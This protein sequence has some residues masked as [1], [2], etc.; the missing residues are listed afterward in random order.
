MAASSSYA[1]AVTKATDTAR[2]A[3]PPPAR[4]KPK[5]PKQMKNEVSVGF[6]LNTNGWSTYADLGKVKAL[7]AKNSDMFHNVRF[8]QVEFT[9][10]KS[11]REQKQDGANTSG[12]GPTTYIYGK[13]N[14][15]YALKIGYGLRKMIAGKPD[16]GTVS[17]HWLSAIG[18]SAG[19]L[20]PYYIN[21]KDF[22]EPI[23]YSDEHK[24]AFLDQRNILGNVGFSK[25][26]GEIG[27][28][29]GGHIKTGLHFDFSTNKKNVLGVEVGINAELYSKKVEIMAMQPPTNYFVDLF[30]GIQFGKRW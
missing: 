4:I 6:R 30:L 26:L 19:F 17:I 16:P 3:T 2:K 23:K 12:T 15:F 14:N 25:G 11:P 28:V 18:A 8:F 20:K 29:P 22:P 24:T 13:I 5:L 9:E 7:D 10:K 21:T 27:I 1:Q